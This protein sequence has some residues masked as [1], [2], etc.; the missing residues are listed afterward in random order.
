MQQMQNR[1]TLI[2]NLGSDVQITT[3]TSGKKVARTSIA[4]HYN[5]KLEDGTYEQTT[6]WH[7]LV[8]WDAKAEF[9]DK[10]LEKGS[11]VIVYG[12]LVHRSYEDK[13]GIVRYISEIVI[14]EFETPKKKAA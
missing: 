1:V 3:L 10:L 12:R 11:Y 4:T 7:K 2:G 13:E 5:R 9:M 14:R 6:Q 8:G